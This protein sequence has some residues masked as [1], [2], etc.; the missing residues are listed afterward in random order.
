MELLDILRRKR[1]GNALT[2][3]EIA[4]FVRG[5][6]A[7]TV[8]DEQA[9]AML[10]AI[11]FR[12]MT[13]QELT[14]LTMCMARSGDQ[15]D[16][17]ALGDRTADKHST[18]GVG[19]KTSLIA[20]PIAA[21]LGVIVPKMSGR[22]LGHTG[23]TIDKL[24]AIPGYRTD[25]PKARFRAQVAQIGLAL[26]SQTG[27]LAPADKRMY[28]LRDVT[29]TVESI[30]LIASSVM[31]KKLAAGARNIV[32]DV[33]VGAG[34]FMKTAD[35][36]RVLAEK[37]V[38][39]GTRCGRRVTALLTRM[40][41]PLGWAIGNAL[42]TAEA[43]RVLRGTERGDVRTLSVRLAAEMT[44]LALAI[45]VETALRQAEQALDSGAALA[46]MRE[47]IAAQGGDVRVI[48]DET[49]LPCGRYTRTVC[50]ES[51]G[52]LTQIDAEQLGRVSVRLGAGRMVKNAPVD[53]GAG[54]V[55][56][57]APGDEVRCGTPL[58][59]LYT[60]RPEVLDEA[61]AECARAFRSGKRP[62]TNPPLILGEIRGENR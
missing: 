61:A 52:F 54:I 42:E 10:M 33:K 37:M 29:A 50:A 25:L 7:G 39:I 19:D 13:D 14:D 28:A 15:I 32:L 22:G 53:P 58:C 27:H 24:E 46:K 5:V 47:W 23:G 43:I 20:A 56:A 36:A 57:H 30:P 34:A 44:S 3:A 49:R 26:V 38:E 45:P 8:P 18:G 1:D 51:G 11:Y 2:Q 12:G 9:A 16:W 17:S 48:D 35:D 6:T 60:S 21:S 40:D 62:P 55:L 4:Y 59:R 41:A 31:S